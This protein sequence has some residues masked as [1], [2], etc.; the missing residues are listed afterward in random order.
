MGIGSS[1][2]GTVDLLGVVGLYIGGV[3]GAGFASG[4]ELTVFFLRFG[5]GG[6]AG[7][8]V[9]V[10]L[11]TVGSGLVLEFCAERGITS[12]RGLF[13]AFGFHRTGPFE[14]AYSFILIMG[15]A[16]MLAGCAALGAE[17]GWSEPYRLLTGVLLLVVLSSGRRGIL[18]VS[19]WLGPFIG[20]FMIV[21]AAKQL[22]SSEI[23]VA[24]FSEE[25]VLRGM[26]A[27][28]LYASYNLG[29]SVAVLAAV[30]GLFTRAQQRR[31]FAVIS[32]LLL[33][34]ALLLLTLALSTL[35]PHQLDVQLPVLGIAAAGGP[36]IL[37]CYRFVLWASMYTT[38][39]ANSFALTGRLTEKGRLSWRW[40]A[41]WVIVF[42]ITL[43]YI[44]FSAL[45]R[46]VY[47]LLGLAVLWFFLNLIWWRWR[48]VKLWDGNF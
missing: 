47:P 12:Y 16:V 33:G 21:L 13:L 38:A 34:S 44:G 17:A 5:R 46:I 11:L 39:L 1:G 23:K 4:Q 43:S 41:W 28:L 31:A 25:S 10:A 48:T 40:S 42:S 26:E 29:F 45:I 32:N 22:Q 30:S 9:T 36:V 3:I 6:L 37:S 2:G 20:L 19:R 24:H 27:G 35:P 15:N 8:L 18:G 14:W 7:V